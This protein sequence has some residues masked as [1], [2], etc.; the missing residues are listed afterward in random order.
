M[1]TKL[2]GAIRAPSARSMQLGTKRPKISWSSRRIRLGVA[3]HGTPSA[4][5]AVSK[6]TATERKQ[7]GKKRR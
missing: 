5:T 1:R 4:W 3:H 6:D 7:P 2:R